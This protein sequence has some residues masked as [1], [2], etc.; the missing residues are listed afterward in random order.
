[1]NRQDTSTGAIVIASL[2][3][4]VMLIVW[5][6]GQNTLIG[7]RAYEVFLPVA[8]DLGG[9]GQG[10]PVRLGGHTIS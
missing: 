6:G 9:I 10:Y 1:M 7:G 3:I 2:I 8:A 4:T 5:V